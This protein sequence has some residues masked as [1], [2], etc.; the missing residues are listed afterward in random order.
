MKIRRKKEEERKGSE[1]LKP[2]KKSEN[3]GWVE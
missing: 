2:R 3:G 1:K